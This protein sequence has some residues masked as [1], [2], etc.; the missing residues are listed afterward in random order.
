MNN[1]SYANRFPISLGLFVLW[2]SRVEDFREMVQQE[3]SAKFDLV[4]TREV[5]WPSDSLAKNCFRFYGHKLSSNM[6][7]IK[8]NGLNRFIV[9]VVRDTDPV[10]SFYSAQNGVQCV[11]SNFVRA[12][13][14][15]RE[16]LNLSWALHGANNSTEAAMDYWLL[17]NRDLFSETKWSQEP[18]VSSGV[19]GASGWRDTQTLFQTLN[20]CESYVILRPNIAHDDLLSESD[21]DI[22]VE[23]RESFVLRANATKICSG[24]A[25]SRYMLDIGDSEI[26]MDV[27]YVGD[28]YFDP[29]FQNECLEEKQF[30]P[31]SGVYHLSENHQRFASLYHLLVHKSVDRFDNDFHSGRTYGLSYAEAI[32]ELY[33]QMVERRLK[34]VEPDDLTVQFNTAIA[35]GI[36]ISRERKWRNG[37]NRFDRF[38]YRILRLLQKVLGCWVRS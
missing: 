34:F 8:F 26:A 12:K 29:K 21:I 33:F 5:S 20:H 2:P 35:R 31:K 22:L 16:S 18:I 14:Y 36:K 11:N 1:Q 9:Y 24:N 30:C 13:S 6:L 27:H 37:K 4:A 3:L 15:L 25:R 7:K 28:G 38:K 10:D 23:D 19:V 32:N 17:T